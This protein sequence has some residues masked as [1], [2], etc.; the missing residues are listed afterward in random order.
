MIYP[1]RGH[2]DL[3]ALVLL[4]Y[5]VS[6]TQGNRRQVRELGRDNTEEED[7]GE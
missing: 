2:Q 6:S 5:N 7:Q 3:D 1:Y 4:V